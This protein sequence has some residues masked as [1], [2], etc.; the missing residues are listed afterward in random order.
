MFWVKTIGFL[1]FRSRDKGRVSVRVNIDQKSHTQN[2]QH[3]KRLP[4]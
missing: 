4:H 3:S 2:K 1:K